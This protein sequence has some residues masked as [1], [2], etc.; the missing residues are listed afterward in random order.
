M[1]LQKERFEAWLFSQPREREVDLSDVNNC[2]LCRF[3]RETTKL[4]IYALWHKLW[5][6]FTPQEAILIPEWFQKVVRSGIEYQ[7]TFGAMQDAF[8]ET[9]KEVEE[10]Q[11]KDNVVCAPL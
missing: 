11:H 8:R 3:Y 9:F 5:N 7:T 6:V 4:H 10:K 1:E 2:L